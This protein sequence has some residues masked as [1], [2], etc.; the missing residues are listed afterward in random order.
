MAQAVP[1]IVPKTRGLP[2][3]ATIVASSGCPPWKRPSKNN[4]TSWLIG[5]TYL[6]IRTKWAIMQIWTR[7]LDYARDTR[8]A[9]SNEDSKYGEIVSRPDNSMSGVRMS[10]SLKIVLSQFNAFEKITFRCDGFLGTTSVQN[11]A[12]VTKAVWSWHM[13]MYDVIIYP[14]LGRLQAKQYFATYLNYVSERD[15]T[16]RGGMSLTSARVQSSEM[17][18]T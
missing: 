3:D 16:S 9:F 13:Q 1:E 12:H 17:Y 15:G 2:E 11:Y 4:T 7:T 14:C 18:M 5:I 8:D 6:Q 10:V